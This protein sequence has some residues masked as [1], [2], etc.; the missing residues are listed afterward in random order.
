MLPH[1]CCGV[2]RTSAFLKVWPFPGYG[3]SC[4]T[5]PGM[6]TTYLVVLVATFLA[7]AAMTV[8]ILLK[9]FAGQR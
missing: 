8:V 7:I 5:L 1:P 6:E 9:L 4:G 3:L 2:A